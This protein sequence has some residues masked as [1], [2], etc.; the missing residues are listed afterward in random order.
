MFVNFHNVVIV[1]ESNPADPAVMPT[2]IKKPNSTR[3]LEPGG[4]EFN[5]V[6]RNIMSR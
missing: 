5:I 1:H 3:S 6:D 2:A 4:R